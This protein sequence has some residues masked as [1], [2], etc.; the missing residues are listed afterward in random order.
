[1]GWITLRANP[2]HLFIVNPFRIHKALL[3]Q[4]GVLA[5]FVLATGVMLF[6]LSI[7]FTDHVPDWGDPLENTWVLAWD[8]HALVDNP[9][10]LYNANIFYPY[11]N[12]LAFSESQL[13]SAALGRPILFASNNPILSYNFVF[14]AAFVLCG[15]N[16]YLFV[17]DVV[18]NR[19]GALVAGA[20]FAF[21]AYKF[22]HLSHIN[23]ITL[24]WLALVLFSL[25]RALSQDRAVFSILFGV[26]LL[27]QALSSWYAALMT[28]LLVALYVLYR[29]VQQR[30]KWIWKRWGTFAICF[31]LALVPLAL[32][33]LPYFQVSGELQFARS[34]ADAERFSARPLSFLSVSAFNLLY[35]NMLPR[36]VGEALFP[37]ALVLLLALFG[38]RKRAFFADRA[39]WLMAIVFF[40]VLAFGPIFHLT[41]ALE[42]PLPLYQFLYEFVPG[43]QGTRAPARFF[44]VGMLGLTLLAAS[45]FAVV[46]KNVSARAR[47]VLLAVALAVLCAEYLA[48]PLR[49]VGV[50]TG[51]Q[52]PNVYAWLQQQPAG[53]V[54]ELPVATGDIEPITRA[55]Y[56]SI[57]HGRA[58]PLGYASFIPPTQ[59]DFLFTLNTAL[60]TPSPRVPNMLRE[61]GVRYVILHLDADNAE[62]Y[63]HAFAQL[64]S[65]E[66]VYEDA[67]QRVYFIN[68]DAPAHPLQFDCLAPAYAAPNA[69]YIAYLTAQHGRRYPIVNDDLQTHRVTLTWQKGGDSFTQTVNAKLPYVLRER[70]E[71]VAL[72]VTA[73]GASGDYELSC[74]LDGAAAPSL[75]QTVHISPAFQINDNSP[76]L[77]LLDVK[78]APNPPQRGGELIVTFFWR[79]RA[80]IRN[81]VVMQVDLQDENGN[82]ISELAREPI[83][84]TYPVRLWREDEL[85]ADSYALPIPQD[86]PTGNYRVVIRAWNNDADAASVFRNP[87]GQ[88]T[89]EFS[90]EPFPLAP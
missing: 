80:E 79:R 89:T 58:M 5:L 54:L 82:V 90:T 19:G 66:T 21:W 3:E 72:D 26:T 86:A 62:F 56:F 48:I 49:L 60:Q 76:L 59:T 25:R 4:I 69:P 88:A 39:F 1:M 42:F 18:R 35:Q 85:V 15:F 17:Y 11:P 24:Q 74:A 87:R 71:G 40:G 73:P 57:Y 47:N 36:A 9:L 77:E 38:L 84:Y 64:P 46:T 34:L 2:S 10:D 32:V 22:N 78:L 53:N 13:A 27:L 8:A 45:G 67:T 28:L 23:L 61:F 65:F 20:A 30:G 12:A 68:A 6:P 63:K 50:E 29:F 51:V 33:G 7:Q 52:V 14:L 37:G 16:T 44:V 41:S 75:T 31:G 55:M 70:A 43:F 81:G 83:L